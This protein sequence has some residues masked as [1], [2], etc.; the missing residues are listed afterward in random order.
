MA[1]FHTCCYTVVCSLASQTF[2]AQSDLQFTAIFLLWFPD[3][4]D[5]ITL[6]TTRCL[7]LTWTE[8][9]KVCFDPYLWLAEWYVLGR[10]VTSL[11]CSLDSNAGVNKSQSGRFNTQVSWLVKFSVIKIWVGIHVAINYFLVHFILALQAPRYFRCWEH[12]MRSRIYT[13]W[14]TRIYCDWTWTFLGD[15][16]VYFLKLKHVHYGFPTQNITYADHACFW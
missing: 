10:L 16:W 2:G 15:Q 3:C 6:K 4:W 9:N 13:V 1:S 7:K 11:L 8:W 12:S 14:L 5:Y